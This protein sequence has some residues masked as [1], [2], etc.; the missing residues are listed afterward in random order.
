VPF[1]WSNKQAQVSQDVLSI[2][3]AVAGNAAVAAQP[4]KAPATKKSLFA[5]R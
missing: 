1:V 2:A 5:W 3:K 4:Q